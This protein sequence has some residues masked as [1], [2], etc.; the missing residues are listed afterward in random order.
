ME[1]PE[2]AR[3]ADLY[4]VDC[5]LPGQL[6]QLGNRTYMTPRRP[7][8]TT[9]IDCR[10]R[11]GEYVAY[12]RAD[13]KTALRIWLPAAEDGDA[14]A[15][16]TV[17]EIFEQGLGTEP[18]FEVAALW[19]G[20]A[21]E[22]GHK[23]ALFNLG[24]LYETGRGVE[25]DKVQALNL[26][27]RAWGV[28]DDAL[29]RESDATR[30]LLR[31]AEENA[32]TLEAE[33]RAA[34]TAAGIAMEMAV[35]EAEARGRAQGRSERVREAVVRAEP[36]DSAEA[37]GPTPAAETASEAV[38]AAV[39]AGR[40]RTSPPVEVSAAGRNFGRY[41][42]LVIGNADY[43][44]LDDLET[45]VSDAQRLAGVLERRYGFNVRLLPNSDDAGLLRALN[46]LNDELDEN[47][48]LLIYYSGHGNRRESGVY[49]TG[50]WLPVNAEPAPNDT[51]W[52][53][54]EQVS[55]HLARLKAKRIIVVADSSYA[56][57]LADNPAFLLATDMANLQS[58]AYVQLRF[59]NRSRLLMTSGMDF[60]LQEVGKLDQSVFADALIAVLE[61]NDAVLTAPALF[62]QVLDELE[63][64]QPEL[65]PQFKAIKRAG[66]EVGDFFFVRQS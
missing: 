29:V 32:R 38:A 45:P 12:D 1:I 30:A 36:A 10:V 28:S 64:R 33:R 5:L 49:D 2:D 46:Q 39:D 8:R 14:D 42:A 9:A 18:N 15:Q 31:Q 13:Y 17:G 57:L 25:Q 19:Y 20:R 53:P 34:D 4:I 43:D 58:E 51:F 16:N 11:G 52:V 55:G 35:A 22:Q 40:E 7:V 50:Y 59:P 3:V 56:G 47:D 26:Y 54:T 27:R 44:L 65:N 21:A 37:T 62:L 48:N 23:T 24:T 61:G 6:R 66:D 60:P 41:Y 63:E